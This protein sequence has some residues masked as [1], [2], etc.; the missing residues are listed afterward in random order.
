MHSGS[1]IHVDP[2]Q[3][4]VSYLSPW[5]GP[6]SDHSL[7]WWSRCW[8]ATLSPA[9][10]SSIERW[11]AWTL[12][13]STLQVLLRWEV[14]LFLQTFYIN[15]ICSLPRLNRST[16]D[17]MDERKVGKSSRGASATWLRI[18]EMKECDW[19]LR[20]L[21]QQVQTEVWTEACFIIPQLQRLALPT[22]RGF[23]VR[24]ERDTM[25]PLVL[26]HTTLKLSLPSKIKASLS[27]PLVSLDMEMVLSHQMKDLKKKT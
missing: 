4:R 25:S 21:F 5:W 12:C 8:A 6:A 17:S 13:M 26:A 19:S 3:L 27:L 10:W 14:P 16:T 23:P 20:Q 22:V 1:P 7:W 15:K 11:Y 18:N 24:S 2:R 9:L